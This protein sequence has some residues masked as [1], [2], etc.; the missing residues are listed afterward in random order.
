MRTLLLLL[1]S[2]A[3]AAASAVAQDRAGVAYSSPTY[4]LTAIDLGSGE[5][6]DSPAHKL[7]PVLGTGVVA[8]PDSA[9]A[10]YF[11]RGGFPAMLSSATLGAP[12]L[13][14]VDPF[15]VGQVGSPSAVVAGYDLLPG[16]TPTVTIGGQPATV[17]QWTTDHVTVDVPDQSVPGF[18]PVTLTNGVG[19]A[20]LERGVAVLPLLFNREPLNLATPVHST[21]VATQGDVA[22]LA[23]SFGRLPGPVPAL[24][25][26]Y[27]LLLDPNLLITTAL[28]TVTEADGTFVL[29]APPLPVVGQLYYQALVITTNP[30][31][32]PW[33]WTNDVTL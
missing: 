15:F 16:G 20:Q 2:V 31:Y 9:S 8:E 7:R 6:A 18:Q 1:A 12:M 11:L 27:G 25:A 14:G 17:T 5:E 29:Q 13:A 23:L 10:T 24:G 22:L 32:A 28:I 19:I 21:L 4:F 33:S 3:G 26:R 30:T